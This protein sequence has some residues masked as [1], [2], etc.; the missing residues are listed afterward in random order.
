M[1]NTNILLSITFKLNTMTSE[2]IKQKIA[3][4][5]PQLDGSNP[6]QVLTQMRELDKQLTQAK[7]VELLDRVNAEQTKL[8]TL[9]AQ[10]WECGTPD[11]DITTSDGSFHKTKVKKYPKIAALK[12]AYAKYQDGKMYELQVNGERFQL[13]SRK[14]EYN[15]PTVYT[16]PESFAAF[17]ELNSIM[18]EP[19]T[20]EQ[21][22]ATC[23]K[24]KEANDELQQHIK[25]YK[26]KLDT[27]NISSLQYWRLMGQHDEHLYTYSPNS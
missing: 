23:E 11:E 17:L 27:L 21:F 25:E 7:R 16:R 3:T 13:Y 14:F 24:L 5:R 18:P 1:H 20:A 8:R 9:A 6:K 10:V 26:A 19:I 15:K 4:L 12:Y 22:E 2:Q